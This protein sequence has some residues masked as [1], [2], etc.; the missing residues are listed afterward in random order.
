ITSY[1][2]NFGDGAVS[3]TQH[4]A[5]H[6]QK[7]GNYS[8]QLKVTT[9]SGCTD[10]Y[11]STETVHVYDSPVIRISGDSAMCAPASVSFKGVIEKGDPSLLQWRWNLPNGQ[12]STLQIPAQQQYTADGTY[13]ISAIATNEHGC[14]D[15]ATKQISVFPL[16]TTNAGTDAW[17]CRGS[18]AQLKA[19]GATTY[20]W[21]ASS[22][23]S[24]TNCSSPL[25]APTEAARYVVTGYN[26]YGCSSTD[27]VTINVHQPFNL[28]VGRGDTVCLGETVS[29]MAGGAD[30]YTWSPSSDV[31]NP[32][33]GTTTA[34]PN[35]STLYTVIGRDKAGCFTDT[36]SVYVKV[37]NIPSVSV[38]DAVTLPVGNSIILKPKYSTDVTSYLW[39]HPQTLSCATCPTPV[40]KP[41]MATTYSIAVKND[42]GCMAKDEITVQVVCNNGNLF[43][44]NTFSPNN[45]GANDQFYPR[46]SGISRIK[47]M[48]IFNRWGEVVFSRENFDVNDA[49]AG[50][51]GSYKGRLLPPDVYI[52]TCEVVC[53]NNEVLTYKGDVTLLR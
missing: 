3:T 53:I 8:V 35:A 40:A 47:S 45:D 32:S 52:Y 29:L 43:I 31:K 20:S 36:G 39:S 51:D 25:A 49:T 11:V 21:Q 34:T 44:P 9:Q 13:T 48:T 33:S 17:I 22:S 6:Y 4:P 10:T 1:Q 2:W 46:G 14:S 23:L 42:G 12:T 38:E 18:F 50:W 7:A 28:T 16:P 30:L 5:H 15:T 26:S 19:T 27:T 24:C 41:K 37:W